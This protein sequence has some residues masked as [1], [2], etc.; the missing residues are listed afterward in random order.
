MHSTCIVHLC[1][2]KIDEIRGGQDSFHLSV[3]MC[4]KTVRCINLTHV[5]RDW[6]VPKIIDELLK[7]E[8]PI[9]RLPMLS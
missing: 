8:N 3:S 1:W 5:R 4:D 9:A 6:I 2:Q 7:A